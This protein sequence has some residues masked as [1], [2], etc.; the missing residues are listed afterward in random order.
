MKKK[1][2]ILAIILLFGGFSHAQKQEEK[3]SSG[4]G[5]NY[6][7]VTYQNNSGQDLVLALAQGAIG[8][9]NVNQTRWLKLDSKTNSFSWNVPKPMKASDLA[10][11]IFSV[12]K[13]KSI[14]IQVPAYKEAVGFRCLIADTIFKH[15]AFQHMYGNPDSAAYMAFPDL[16]TD[17]YLFDKF[18][19]GLTI[20]YPGVWNITAV[21]FVAIPMQLSA[22]GQTVGFKNGV[23][24]SGLFAAL[25]QLGKPYN[26]GGSITPNSSTRTYRFFSPAHIPSATTALDKLIANQAPAIDNS[27][28]INYGN[29]VFSNLSGSFSTDSKGKVTGTI[30]A[31]YTCPTCKITTKRPISVNDVTTVRSF[32]GTIVGAPNSGSSDSLAQIQLGAIV[33]AAICRGILSQPKL[34]GDIVHYKSNCPY[35][36]NYYPSG[37]QCDLYSKVIHQYS[38]NSKNYGF[39]Y[40]DYFG[41]EAGFTVLP[42]D[43]VQV[44]ILPLTGKMT[45]KP[46]G[47][48]SHNKGCLMVTVPADSIY[49]RSASWSIGTMSVGSNRVT[50]GSSI[51]C[52]LPNDTIVCTFSSKAGLQMKLFK[53][54]GNG[55]L[56]YSF[57]DNSKSSFK[58]NGI[59]GMVYDSIQHNLTFSNSA[60]WQY[61]NAWSI[62]L[63]STYSSGNGWNVGKITVNGKPLVSGSNLSVIEKNQKKGDTVIC[64]FSNNPNLLMC[65]IQNEPLLFLDTLGKISKINGISGASYDSN[66]LTLSFGEAA[67]FQYADSWSVILP[68]TYPSGASWDIDTIFVNQIPL[69]TGQN[70]GLIP[71]NGAAGDTVTCT[72]ANQSNLVMCLIENGPLLFK[73]KQGNPSK[74]IRITNIVYDSIN[75]SLTFGGAAQFEYANSW[76]INLPSTYPAGSGWNIDTIFVNG[77]PLVPG[78]NGNLIQD[79]TAKY[80][81][82]LICTFSSKPGLQMCLML[83]NP[84]IFRNANGE[85][86]RIKGIIGLPTGKLKSRILNFGAAASWSKRKR[87]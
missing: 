12:K 72:F 43:Q 74:V 3:S 51:F 47:T 15:K 85:P 11:Y 76:T 39:P 22:N 4:G 14:T 30:S 48:M 9:Q 18:E 13:G 63:P 21:D 79:S 64:R 17:K 31:N 24:A 28:T 50:A 23:T 37:V 8:S 70:S 6:T 19:A 84:A 75:R 41:D 56:A 44:T 66:N 16:E 78:M 82:T 68:S 52:S 83:G 62:N 5:M 65:L 81:D 42:G 46:N 25:N 69:I 38:I 71:V 73:D 26:Q 80:G 7:S 36:W 1:L 61:S 32:A 45:A 29:Y 59:T 53:S 33:S 57:S 77:I 10:P 49:E 20:G 60:S 2:F 40:D 35:P 27:V 58:I 34:W 67:Q 87:H 54:P 86:T 55:K